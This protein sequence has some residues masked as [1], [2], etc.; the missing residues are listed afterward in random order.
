MGNQTIYLPPPT[1]NS[2]GTWYKYFFGFSED[3]NENGFPRGRILLDQDLVSN[4][5]AFT[6][7]KN[8]GIFFGGLKKH[9]FIRRRS[10]LN[11]KTYPELFN[12]HSITEELTRN[13]TPGLRIPYEIVEDFEITLPVN[14]TNLTNI[15]SALLNSS[16]IAE[17]NPV[18]WA[19]GFA[20]L[21]D[22]EFL[23]C[24]PR[25]EEHTSL[26][27]L[28]NIKKPKTPEEQ[29][30]LDLIPIVKPDF[31]FKNPDEKILLLPKL[32]LWKEPIMS[33]PIA[34]SG[35]WTDIRI[36]IPKVLLEIANTTH[37]EV[38]SLWQLYFD[39]LGNLFWVNNS[40]QWRFYLG[41]AN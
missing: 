21:E 20:S 38:K 23:I 26:D 36:P 28:F 4:Y 7:E 37:A 35:T 13:K 17:L 16:E 40:D 6:I 3:K 14:R 34:S 41:D 22:L 18:Y 2:T 15:R 1:Y 25:W 30:L 33:K 19:L 29:G 12:D 5:P 31:S 8:L 27:I 11:Q 10:T 39:T 32:Y 9:Q 24:F